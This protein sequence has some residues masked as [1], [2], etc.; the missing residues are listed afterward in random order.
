MVSIG[1][2]L[3]MIRV[4]LVIAVAVV[5]GQYG[6]IR[7]SFA[8]AIAHAPDY[9]RTVISWLQRIESELLPLLPNQG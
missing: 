1:I 3:T 9:Y 5:L 6:G 7:D 2:T 8:A 4:F